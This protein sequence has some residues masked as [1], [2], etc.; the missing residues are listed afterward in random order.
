MKKYSWILGFLF[1]SSIAFGIY[2]EP[3]YP[4][5]N[6]GTGQT[7]QQAALDAIMASVTAGYYPRGN[8]THVTMGPLQIADI[9]ALWTA[10]SGTQYL[11]YDGNCHTAGTGTVT[12]LSV[13]S[14]NGFTGTSSG[15]ATPA[16]TLS[17]SV[18]GPLKGSSGAL[19][20]AASSDIVGLFSSCSGTQYLGADGACHTASGGGFTNPMTTLGD[21]I[22]ENATPAAARLAGSTSASKAF[23]V[24]TGTGSVSAAPAWQVGLS[25]SDMVTPMTAVGDLIQGG[26]SGA[27]TRLAAGT[28]GQVLTAQGS[29]SSLVWSSPTNTNQIVMNANAWREQLNP[30]TP[31][32][33][34]GSLVYSW[35]AG[36][37]Q[38]L[39]ANVTV[40]ATYIT[41]NKITMKVK[42]YSS[43]YT[44]GTDLMTTTATL[45]RSG[46]DSMSSTTNQRTSTNTAV[47]PSGSLVPYS[48]TFD[49]T[50]TTGKINS[51]AVSAGDTIVV[52]LTRGTDTDTASIHGLVF[53][54]EI[55]T[56]PVVVAINP[57]NSAGNWSG[58]STLSATTTS[59]SQADITTSL[60][61]S[62]TTS[63]TPQNITCSAASAQIGVTCTLPSLGSYQVCGSGY[64]SNSNTPENDQVWLTDGSNVI[65][66][67]PQKADVAYTNAT[68]SFK[69]CAPYTATSLTPTFKL[70]GQVSNDTGT[71]TATNFSVTSLTNSMAPPILVGGVTSTGSGQYHM[72]YLS[73]GGPGGSVGLPSN[74][75]TSPCTIYSQSGG[76]SS[77]TLSSSL[78]TDVYT[79]NFTAGEFSAAPSCN[80]FISNFAGGNNAVPTQSGA[81]TNTSS[82]FNFIV[83]TNAGSNVTAGGY[84]QCMGPH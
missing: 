72:E 2:I 66:D 40:P 35:S 36:A 3:P 54:G 47:T 38:T 64:M 82:A 27:E 74:C 77:V 45:V 46:T 10:C 69:L 81:T 55:D 20:A 25:Q 61:G 43:G 84:V 73:F 83:T 11:G 17:T 48:V 19:A 62:V 51:V 76:I 42:F 58:T 5:S 33:E 18:S 78:A 22:Y 37:A 80:V 63:G 44:S 71:Y 60:S 32:D 21:L 41:G 15:G 28:L 31:V 4:F 57:S 16:L 30:P 52:A 59:T 67:G 49:L 12:S 26:A 53:T 68:S 79:I 65:I 29:S 50:D 75:S 24:Q 13:A 6:G 8:G 1:C 70:R 7:T 14:S 34:Y 39:Y 9:T 56:A 23:L